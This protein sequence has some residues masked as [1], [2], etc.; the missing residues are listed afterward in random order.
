LILNRLPEVVKVYVHASAGSCR[1]RGG[2]R[3][4]LRRGSQLG[5]KGTYNIITSFYFSQ[6]S[7]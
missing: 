2:C 4:K 3:K 6:S 5:M 7:G 1:L